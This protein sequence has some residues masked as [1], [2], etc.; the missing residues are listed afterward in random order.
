MLMKFLVCIILIIIFSYFYFC[1]GGGGREEGQ[2]G[3]FIERGG[4]YHFDQNVS[5]SLFCHKPK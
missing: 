1:L 5:L 3:L 2:W 4:G